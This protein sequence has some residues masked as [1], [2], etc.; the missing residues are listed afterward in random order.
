MS[1]IYIT[2]KMSS[3]TAG[4]GTFKIRAELTKQREI[5]VIPPGEC[6]SLPYM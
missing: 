1:I 6:P 3:K 2:C 5:V 4:E